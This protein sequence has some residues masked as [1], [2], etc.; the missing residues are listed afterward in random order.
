MQNDEDN[1]LLKTTKMHREPEA[2]D[3][4]LILPEIRG[5]PPM[6]FASES[7]VDDQNKDVKKVDE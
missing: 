2:N 3:S 7:P 1:Q 6:K 5:R 4:Q